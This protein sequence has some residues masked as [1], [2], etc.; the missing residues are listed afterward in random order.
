MADTN[1]TNLS[2]VKP[3]VGASA[4][5]WGSK[6]NANFDTI[7]GLF[8][9][10]PVLK[11]DKGGTGAATA[12]D[13]R[14]NLGAAGVGVANTFTANQTINGSLTIS[15][16][17]VGLIPTGTK[18]LF[19]QTSAPTG[20][21]KDTT[22]DNKALRVVSGTAGAGGSSSFTTAFANRTGTTD[23]TT[24][25]GTVG[26]TTL[27]AN[28]IPAHQHYVVS[29]AST[30]AT[31]DASDTIAGQG[32]YSGDNAYILSGDTTAATE[33]LTSSIG[34]G[35]SH[36][37]TFTGTSHTHGFSLDI[38]VAYVDLIIATKN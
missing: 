6:N 32:N 14:S 10:G 19:Q 1:T 35:Q 26:A 38:S 37:H 12:A 31:L 11:I 15:G 33:G 4:D 8:S 2:L 30:T 36:T 22:H 20:W 23:A 34:G 27:T 21:T 16:S 7:D 25:G 29:T 28:Q 24:A 3:E 17:I 9:A 5:T 18:M 13:A